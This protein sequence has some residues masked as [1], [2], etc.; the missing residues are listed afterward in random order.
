M[1]E[2]LHFATYFDRH[3]IRLGTA[4]YQSLLRH[5]PTFVLWVLCLDDETERTL[6]SLGLEHLVTVR[7]SELEQA[8]PALLAAKSDRLLIEYYWTCGP[9]FLLHV[10]ERDCSVQALTYVDSDIFFFGDPRPVFDE[11]GTS[12]IL[13]IPHRHSPLDADDSRPRQLYNV[14]L[15]VFRPTTSGLACLRWWRE[16]CLEWCCDRED[17]ARFGDQGYVNEWPT[18]FDGVMVAQHEGAGVGPWN[19]GNYQFSYDGDR[20]MV[21]QSTLLFYHF[22]QMRRINRWMYE[23]HDWRFHRRT[24]PF[25]VRR[26]IYAPYVRELYAAEQ[27]IRRMGG[28]IHPGEVSRSPASTATRRRLAEHGSRSPLVRS[29]RFMIVAGSFVL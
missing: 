23:L 24:M 20:V 12:S 16:K 11:L 19:L 14:G 1:T 18:R 22:S 6:K 10:F 27:I 9:A 26:H 4:L 2:R 25:V 28:H 17:D 15:I 29:Q 21:N 7:L 8:D 3:Y 13:V 5:N